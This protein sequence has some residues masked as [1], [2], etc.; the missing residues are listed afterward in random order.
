MGDPPASPAA[1]AFRLPDGR[2]MPARGE[3]KIVAD[4]PWIGLPVLASRLLLH[5]TTVRASDVVTH[6]RAGRPNGQTAYRILR[7]PLT[8]VLAAADRRNTGRRI[9]GLVG[10]ILPTSP[11]A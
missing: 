2:L 9:H 11:R 3:G 1:S 4:K 6:G 10:D 5:L 8:L 7:F